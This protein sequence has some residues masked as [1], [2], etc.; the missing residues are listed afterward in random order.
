[1]QKNL[2]SQNKMSGGMFK[3][4]NDPRITKI[5]HFI[6]LTGYENGNVK[7]NDPFSIK[8]SKATWVFANIK[9]QIKAMWV[10]SKK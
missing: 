10:F 9:D 4:D 6:V 3:M 1:M 7:V 2:M 5:G 8:N